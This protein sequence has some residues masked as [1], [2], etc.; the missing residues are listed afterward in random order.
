MRVPHLAK[1]T[2]L[3]PKKKPGNN[4]LQLNDD[5]LLGTHGTVKRAHNFN[6]D[7]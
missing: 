5:I 2:N 1:D 7:F 3:R 6:H 4:Y